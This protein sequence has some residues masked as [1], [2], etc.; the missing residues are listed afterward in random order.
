MKAEFTSFPK[1]T[2]WVEGRVGNL[3]FEA[4]LYDEPSIFGIDKGRVS[5]L[6]IYNQCGDWIVN[7]D[8]GWDISPNEYMDE[9]QAVMELLD[10][11]PERNVEGI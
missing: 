1:N 6:T 4:K 8:R 2:N 7:Y 11:S 5:K 9:Y 10:S 3:T